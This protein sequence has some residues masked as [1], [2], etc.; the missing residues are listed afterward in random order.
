MPGTSA[1]TP[2]IHLAVVGADTR[3][4]EAHPLLHSTDKTLSTKD[5]TSGDGPNTSYQMNMVR[6]TKCIGHCLIVVVFLLF[7]SYGVLYAACSPTM[8]LHI[9]KT[10]GNAVTFALARLGLL[11]GA[12]GE[13]ICAPFGL[14]LRSC[15]SLYPGYWDREVQ[16]IPHQFWNV[17]AC[18]LSPF[19]SVTVIRD[20]FERVVS[21]LKY[22]Y[23]FSHIRQTV[24]SLDPYFLR[25]N[26]TPTSLHDLLASR[27][28]KGKKIM[29][30]NH[31][32]W[33]PMSTYIYRDSSNDNDDD[34]TPENNQTNP[35]D[36]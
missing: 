5:T 21:E 19:A 33:T 17:T 8:F 32:L 31:Y 35:S 28:H 15:I 16:H 18:S 22:Q 3:P 11:T 1:S 9:P 20:P 34:D 30:A 13:G 4:N 10:G 6:F 29:H 24:A 7:F 26:C 12:L 27:L 14:G 25:R 36:R 23:G 2:A